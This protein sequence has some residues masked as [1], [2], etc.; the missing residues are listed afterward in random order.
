MLDLK[1]RRRGGVRLRQQ[2]PWPGGRPPRDGGGLR[3]PGLRA[4]VHPAALLQR[5]GPVPLGRALRRPGRH[6]GDRPA[7]CWRRSPGRTRSPAGSGRRASGSHFQGLPARICWLEYGERAEMGLRFNWLVRHGKV[8]APIVIG[9]DHLDTGSV[10]S[11]NRETEGMRDG[12][13]AIADWPPAQRHAQH[14]VRGELGVAAPRRRCGDR[15]LDPR[16][17]GGRRRRDRRQATA[18][19]SGC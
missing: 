17:H 10:A 8:S 2:P 15:V 14:R 9:R 18:A 4:G 13:D 7:P 16:R 11:P 3:H 1:A 12:S 5:R 6:R 19:S